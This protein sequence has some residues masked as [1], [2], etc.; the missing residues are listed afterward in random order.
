M[1]PQ[2]LAELQT[3]Y[4][5]WLE[6]AGV[7]HLTAF[8]PGTNHFRILIAPRDARRWDGLIADRDAGLAADV[9]RTSDA[10]CSVLMTFNLEEYAT[11]ARSPRAVLDGRRAGV[12]GP[13]LT[14][15]AVRDVDRSAGQAAVENAFAGSDLD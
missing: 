6:K 2:A 1:T 7:D 15:D 13:C 5:A 12:A 10:E 14:F 11:A 8:Q 9:S 4:H 3:R